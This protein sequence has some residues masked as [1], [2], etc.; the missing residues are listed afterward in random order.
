MV[1]PNN[2]KKLELIKTKLQEH[3]EAADTAKVQHD[4]LMAQLKED[5]ECNSLEEAVEL[6]D[7][8]KQE[9]QE[10]E[11]TI[12]DKTNKLLKRIESEGIE[13]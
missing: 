7:D 5:F 11:Q 13:L 4:Y 3:K 1:L 12:I 6:L 2:R 10:L 8:L 9:E